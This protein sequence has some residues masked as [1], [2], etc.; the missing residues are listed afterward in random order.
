MARSAL[1]SRLPPVM[2]D[3]LQVQQLLLNLL[4][5]S[6]EAICETGKPDGSILIADRNGRVMLL[7]DA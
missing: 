3:I 1:P 7:G 2:V 4:R 6:I 5:N